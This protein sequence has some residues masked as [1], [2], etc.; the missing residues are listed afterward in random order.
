LV[1]DSDISLP[2]SLRHWD[3]LLVL[4][5]GCMSACEVI[6]IDDQH[7]VYIVNHSYITAQIVI[8]QV[9]MKP[10]MSVNNN[11]IIKVNMIYCIVGNF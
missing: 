3:R 10:R 4:G 1:D 2:A 7:F 8:T 11:D 5:I 9:K 6:V